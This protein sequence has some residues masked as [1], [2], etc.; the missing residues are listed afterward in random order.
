MIFSGVLNPIY[1]GI[2][3]WILFFFVYLANYSFLF[4][5]PLD[6][7]S[8]P[9]VPF[10]MASLWV[11]VVVAA[12]ILLPSPPPNNFLRASDYDSII[13]RSELE[14]IP[15]LRALIVPYDSLTALTTIVIFTQ[16]NGTL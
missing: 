3:F 1:S 14:Q 7:C 8:F 4:M 15:S 13:A 5:V 12:D 10:T 2:Y 11:F 9:F 16:I 6:L